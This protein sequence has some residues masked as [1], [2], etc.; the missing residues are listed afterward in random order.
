VDD[1]ARARL[2]WGEHVSQLIT[3][4]HPYT[5]FD[6]ALHQHTPDEIKAVIEWNIGQ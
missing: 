2:L 3:N 1:L 4:H 6:T 5:D